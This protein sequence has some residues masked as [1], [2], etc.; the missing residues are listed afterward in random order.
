[1]GG[2]PP[3]FFRTPQGVM[4]ITNAYC[5]QKE[6]LSIFQHKPR[7]QPMRERVS[8]L[9]NSKDPHTK[10]AAKP[11]TLMSFF[12]FWRAGTRSRIVFLEVFAKC[13]LLF[14]TNVIAN[15]INCLVSHFLHFESV[16]R[17]RK[18]LRPPVDPFWVIFC[19]FWKRK[20][21][22]LLK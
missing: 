17:Q 14:C 4:G 21:R 6:L 10:W 2:Y 5:R 18:R 1:M 3:H 11:P 8:P 15:Q 9:Q 7:K 19:V 13:S 22:Q 20:T 16:F 12:D